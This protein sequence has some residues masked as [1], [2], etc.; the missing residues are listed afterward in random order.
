MLTM[1]CFCQRKNQNFVFVSSYHFNKTTIL[2]IATRLL[3]Y[4]HDVLNQLL[5]WHLLNWK[6][7]NK[8][9]SQKEIEMHI[10]KVKKI[11]ID[12]RVFLLSSRQFIENMNVLNS[13]EQQNENREK[14]SKNCERDR[15]FWVERFKSRYIAT[16]SRLI[17]RWVE[18]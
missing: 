6:M 2:F 18:W 15:T 3:K 1:I 11:T 5:E 14:I 12:D 7:S 8:N 17:V 4:T 10:E 9:N 16:C 13:R